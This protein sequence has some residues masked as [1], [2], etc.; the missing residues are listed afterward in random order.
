MKTSQERAQILFSYRCALATTLTLLPA[1]SFA[2]PTESTSP[3]QETVRPSLT[4]ELTP[5]CKNSLERHLGA[6]QPNQDDGA[7]REVVQL[8]PDSSD[9]MQNLKREVMRFSQHLVVGDQIGEGDDRSSAIAGADN[10]A[11][12]NVTS[13]I[14]GMNRKEAAGQEAFL[15]PSDASVAAGPSHF[16]QTANSAIAVIPRTGRRSTRASR[17]LIQS[18]NEHFEATDGPLIFDPRVL[19]DR[20]SRRFF[21]VAISYSR[22]TQRADLW[23]SVSRSNRPKRL[24]TGWCN[25]HFNANHR[26]SSP[27]FPT[28]GVNPDWFVVSTSQFAF[29][30]TARDG[31]LHAVDN[32]ALV[33]NSQRCPR[34][35]M[36]VFEI[37]RDP[38]GNRTLTIQPAHH[39]D[40]G[41]SA[42]TDGPLYM[43]SGRCCNVTSEYALWEL[44]RTPQGPVLSQSTIT[45]DP[46]GIPPDVPQ[47]GGGA[48]FDTGNQR[49]S[50]AVVRNGELFFAHTTGCVQG[51]KVSACVRVARL[52]P[53]LAAVSFAPPRVRSWTFG[54]GADVH[55]F[56]PD[57]AV[58]RD[59]SIM[60]V[61]HVAG[62]RQFLSLGFAGKRATSPNFD[63]FG[64][65][66]RGNQKMGCESNG[67]NRTGDYQ[68][69]AVDPR[70]DSTFVLTGQFNNRGVGFT[71]KCNWDTV[72]AEVA[73]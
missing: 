48:P 70:D 45:G 67:R 37:P 57:L 47:K 33:D 1:L 43:V 60:T 27:D 42:P 35:A 46:Y 7:E 34:A 49:I 55:L 44:R 52:D 19:Y 41:P 61:F 21:V 22:A 56:R 32:R 58:N 68:G 39:L 73:Y 51:G 5:C 13:K 54:G 65:V 16:V 2:G 62:P 9:E 38:N 8:E 6:A 20:V 31:W 69:A 30:G 24:A 11:G 10:V 17:T 15:F 63:P 25:Y 59:G 40:A 28:I 66:H 50:R 3:R 26:G 14:T 36:S 72:V 12:A 18:L 71:S 53:A 29:D 64:F 23:L 4:T